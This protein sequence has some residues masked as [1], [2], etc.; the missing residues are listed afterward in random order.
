[1]ANESQMTQEQQIRSEALEQAVRITSKHHLTP[2]QQVKLS[3]ELA[4]TFEEWITYG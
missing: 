4:K 1:M 2:K 3:M